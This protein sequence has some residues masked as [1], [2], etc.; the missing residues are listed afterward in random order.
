MSQSEPS[1]QEERVL[2]E[3]AQAGDRAATGE[4]L[5]R[6]HNLICQAARKVLSRV[7]GQLEFADL[8]QEGTIGFMHA[9]RKFDLSRGTKFSTYCYWWVRQAI[10]AAAAAC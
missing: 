6:H 2:I 8:V 10:W 5:Q 1:R 3:R 7:Q 9:V 4:L